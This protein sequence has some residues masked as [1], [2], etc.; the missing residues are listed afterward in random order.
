MA[1]DRDTKEFENPYAD[2]VPEDNPLAH[3][4]AGAED[5]E[6]QYGNDPIGP[7]LGVELDDMDEIQIRDIAELVEE[8]QL[9][10]IASP[11][12]TLAEGYEDGDDFDRKLDSSIIEQRREDD[13]RRP[14]HSP[15]D[16]GTDLYRGQNNS[17]VTA[18]RDEGELER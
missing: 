8:E 9:D 3:T 13:L 5:E 7:N 12:S 4:P 1:E 14:P 10:L 11:G 16:T 2:T 18:D 17:D 15:A 6:N